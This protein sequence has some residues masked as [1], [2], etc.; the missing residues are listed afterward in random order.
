MPLFT[1]PHSPITEF[2]DAIYNSTMLVCPTLIFGPV[3][4]RN[5]RDIDTCTAIMVKTITFV[6]LAGSTWNFVHRSRVSAYTF[7]L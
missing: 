1:N 2:T 6:I 3:L 7:F 5:I 4:K